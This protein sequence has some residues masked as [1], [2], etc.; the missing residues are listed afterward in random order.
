[1]SLDI[2]DFGANELGL[3]GNP[4]ASPLSISWKQVEGGTELACSQVLAACR[5]LKE[6]LA[7]VGQDVLQITRVSPKTERWIFTSVSLALSGFPDFLPLLTF[8]RNTWPE[9][10]LRWWSFGRKYP[11]AGNCHYGGDPGHLG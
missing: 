7:M 2:V 5:L 4:T 6:M 8:F 11:G 1:V 10:W 9:T 3:P